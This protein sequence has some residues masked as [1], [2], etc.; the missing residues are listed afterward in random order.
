VYR[1]VRFGVG[2][3][4]FRAGATGARVGASVG[5]AVTAGVDPHSSSGYD[6]QGVR[7]SAAEVAY[8]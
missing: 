4:L 8:Y 3:G 2:T 6:L 1:W 7:R 5:A